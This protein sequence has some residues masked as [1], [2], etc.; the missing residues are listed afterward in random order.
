MR[1]HG[2]G[3]AAAP[4]RCCTHIPAP[5]DDAAGVL[6]WPPWTSVSS[7]RLVWCR[8]QPAAARRTSWS[9]WAH[10][11]RLRK[12]GPTCQLTGELLQI[13]AAL[14]AGRS[15]RLSPPLLASLFGTNG[16]V[17]RRPPRP[18]PV[19]R[20]GRRLGRR[21]RQLGLPASAP[22]DG[23]RGVAGA[24]APRVR[25]TDGRRHAAATTVLADWEQI[26]LGGNRVTLRDLHRLGLFT[27]VLGSGDDVLLDALAAPTS[28]S[29]V[30]QVIPPRDSLPSLP[31]SE[32]NL[33]ISGTS[34]PIG[35]DNGMMGA[36]NERAE[37]PQTMLLVEEGIRKVDTEFACISYLTPWRWCNQAVRW[38]AWKTGTTLAGLVLPD[39]WSW[40]K[41]VGS[42]A[43]QGRGGCSL[44][45]CTVCTEAQHRMIYDR[46]HGSGSFR[47]RVEVPP[48][49][50]RMEC[51]KKEA[52]NPE[53]GG[54]VEHVLEVV[55]G[56]GGLPTM[57]D[58]YFLPVVG[59]NKY[60]GPYKT[61]MLRLTEYVKPLTAIETA[62][63]I[64][65]RGPIIG[66]LAVNP[67]HYFSYRAD[68]KQRAKRVYRGCPE[69]A[70][71]AR[72]AAWHAVVCFEYR[73][74]KSLIGEELQLKIMDSHS[75]DGPRRWICFDAFDRFC[76][77]VICRPPCPRPS[78]SE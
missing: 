5:L 56:M 59:L 4:V 6:C 71:I 34:F 62:R 50:L 66:A 60:P 68:A 3:G 27:V 12:C 10:C 43:V 64:R 53:E 49:T 45:A 24:H 54:K 73:F 41:I 70:I 9:M 42:P 75:P 29:C 17:P 51:I 20:R 8:L 16:A 28:T 67:P 63:L 38:L 65:Q 40:E 52:W 69:S 18:R 26:G 76:L 23:A 35:G 55:V 77:P 14:R 13:A 37:G 1:Y 74:V 31:V 32:P 21:R 7:W 25:R 15:V 39:T 11:Q 72:K 22:R 61:Q 30:V 47:W 58:D 2:D 48:T 78:S 19:P 44:S 33:L 36:D 46:L 57:D